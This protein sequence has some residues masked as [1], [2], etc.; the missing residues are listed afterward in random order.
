MTWGNPV[1]GGDSQSPSV[2]DS[3][4]MQS[5]FFM[6]LLWS[7]LDF[8]QE[9]LRDVQQIEASSG[10]FLAIRADGSVVCWGNSDTPPQKYKP[11]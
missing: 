3:A 8:L 4:I 5:T 9:K 7:S 10:A 2:K 11:S 6:L 1:E